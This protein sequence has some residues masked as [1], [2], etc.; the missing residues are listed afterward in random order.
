MF[1]IIFQ[2]TLHDLRSENKTLKDFYE[3]HKNC[4]KDGLVKLGGGNCFSCK[5]NEDCENPSMESEVCPE[6][7]PCQEKSPVNPDLTQVLNQV[8]P[9]VE[10]T[11]EPEKIDKNEHVAIPHDLIVQ[12]VWKRHQFKCAQLLKQLEE[13]E[14][15][16]IDKFSMVY[17]NGSPI[18][19]SIFELMKISF[20]PIK[21]VSHLNLYINLLNDYNLTNY[22]TNRFLLLEEKPFD[23]KYWYFIG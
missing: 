2:K 23:L 8:A 5:A 14:A 6:S 21:K 19:L 18:H 15:F 7:D 17:I 3:T 12:R 20:A 4:S 10:V 22:I 13:I 1:H 11:E 9:K 16:K